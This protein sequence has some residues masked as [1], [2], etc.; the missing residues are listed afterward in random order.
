MTDQ[1][2]QTTVS[3]LTQTWTETKLFCVG[4]GRPTV[5]VDDS[6]LR[7]NRTYMCSECGWTFC[8]PYAPRTRN[9]VH[10]RLSKE[11]AKYVRRESS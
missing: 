5:Y 11:I 7:I 8:H 10:K 2:F 3:G 9:D 1:K 4:C 6:I